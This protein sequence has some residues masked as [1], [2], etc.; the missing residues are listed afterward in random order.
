M[1]SS[2]TLPLLTLQPVADFHHAWVALLL[3]STAPLDGDTLARLLADCALHELLGTVA[4]IVPADPLAI[5]PALAADLPPHRLILRFP[6]QTATDPACHA[7]LTTL[8]NAGFGLMATGFPGVDAPWCAAITSLAVTCPGRNL[9]ADAGDWLRKLP[10]PHLALGSTEDTC[11]GFCKFHWLAGHPA[12]QASQ[13]SKP[14]AATGSLLLK[15]LALIASD[16]DS[17]AIEVLIKRDTH[18]SYHLLKLV[19]SVA[20]APGHKIT[21]FSQAITLLGR[22]QLQR[23]LQLLLYARPPGSTVASALLPRAALRASL[24]EALAK[25]RGL[26][27][28]QQDQAFMAGMFSLLDVLFA[29]P[30]ADVIAPLRL[31]EGVV[32]ALTGNGRPA[33][34]NPLPALLTIA[35]ASEGPP[36]AGLAQALAAAG[37]GPVAWATMLAEAMRWAAQ[38][39]REA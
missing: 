37:I 30:L 2:D 24:M 25:H 6:V 4:C 34:D 38:V 26:T 35:V 3:E 28:E 11:P 14:P 31:P 1:N 22:R 8:H 36:T 39:S 5:D 21:S 15:L 9:S 13:L 32:Q 7:A 12:G 19:N 17:T 33:R 16:A 18:L 27:H 29:L 23:W 10:G 20:F